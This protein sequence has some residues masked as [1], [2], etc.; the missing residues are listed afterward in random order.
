MYDDRKSQAPAGAK[1]RFQS[2]LKWL[3]DRLGFSA[4]MPFVKKKEVPIHR[5]SFWYYIGG[6]A[7]F[8]FFLQIATGTLLLFYYRPSADGAYESIQ[9][10]M[11]EVQ[12]GW[13]IRSIHSWG[14][15]LMIFMAFI[16]MFS[17]MLLKAYREPREITWVS[18]VLLL[19]VV[20]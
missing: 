11:S 17:V 16:H 5:H 8:L 6:M 14:A 15:N 9:F 18:G 7:L 2:L 13:L 1:G 4:L 20:L 10:L 3:D 19:F 12:F